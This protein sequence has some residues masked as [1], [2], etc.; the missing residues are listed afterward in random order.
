MKFNVLYISCHRHS[1]SASTKELVYFYK[2]QHTNYYSMDFKRFF[3]SSF[4]NQTQTQ[5]R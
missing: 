5:R 2:K 4:N 1:S 3:L